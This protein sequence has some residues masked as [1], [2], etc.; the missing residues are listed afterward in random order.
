M[1]IN[2]VF[3]MLYKSV[4][5]KITNPQCLSHH[6]V[7]SAIATFEG[8]GG[9]DIARPKSIVNSQWYTTQTL[10]VYHITKSL[11]TLEPLLPLRVSRVKT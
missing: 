10:K 6:N 1:N 8:F 5:P 9:Q 4:N 11:I 3:K 2:E 7:I